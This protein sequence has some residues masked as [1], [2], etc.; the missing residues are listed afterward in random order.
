MAR[1]SRFGQLLA[2]LLLLAASPASALPAEA[3]P[4]PAQREVAQPAPSPWVT[5]D[6]SGKA[7]TITPTVTTSNGVAS[8]ISPAPDALLKTGTYTLSPTSG[9]VKTTTGLSPVATASSPKGD[10]VFFACQVYVSVDRPF[11]Q[12]QSGSRLNPGKTYY[13][14]FPRSTFSTTL[15]CVSAKIPY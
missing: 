9:A 2:G 8:T 7:A 11:C 3:H 14:E 13:S 5:V 6:A 15:T 12:P 10:G 1:S 4:P